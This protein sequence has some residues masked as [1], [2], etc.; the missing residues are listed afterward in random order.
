MDF[1]EIWSDHK[2]FI[3]TVGVALMALLVFLGI[4]SA[5]FSD[6][7]RRNLSTVASTKAKLRRDAVARTGDIR[8]LEEN[9][10]KLTERLVKLEKDIELVLPDHYR[11]PESNAKSAYSSLLSETRSKVAEVAGLQNVQVPW[12][13]GVPSITPNTRD[14]MQRYLAG[15]Y[16]VQLVVPYAMEEGIKRFESIEVSPIRGGN[17]IRETRVTFR[18]LAGGRAIAGLLDRVLDPEL[19]LILTDFRV[20][21]PPRGEGIIATIQVSIYEVHPDKAVTEEDAA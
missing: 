15:L 19:P 12:E 13:L 5:T 1:E 9:E 20:A 21:R 2:A 11:L 6:D 10:E 4:K 8:A 7:T 18:A 16:V 14:E 3:V 17:F